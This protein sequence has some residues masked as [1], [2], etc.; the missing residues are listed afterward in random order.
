MAK[1]KNSTPKSMDY[2]W[3]LKTKNYKIIWKC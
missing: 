1:F 2:E 3:P